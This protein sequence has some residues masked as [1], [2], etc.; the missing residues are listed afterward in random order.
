VYSEGTQGKMNKGA[1]ISNDGIV[2][3]RVSLS[4][5]TAKPRS[6]TAK[7]TTNDKAMHVT[8][9]GSIRI[10]GDTALFVVDNQH[11]ISLR[12]GHPGNT[13]VAASTI[14]N[15][16]KKGSLIYK[17]VVQKSPRPVDPTV[18]KDKAKV[19]SDNELAFQNPIRGEN[20]VGRVVFDP[21][22]KSETRYIFCINHGWLTIG[23][24]PHSTSECKAYKKAM[25]RDESFVSRNPEVCSFLETAHQENKPKEKYPGTSTKAPLRW[26]STD[27]KDE[28][29]DDTPL[30]VVDIS[31][32][33]GA[34]AKLGFGKYKNM[35]YN[36][37]LNLPGYIACLLGDL[38]KDQHSYGPYAS[39]FYRWLKYHRHIIE[40]NGVPHEDGFAKTNTKSGRGGKK[41]TSSSVEKNEDEV[42]Q[43]TARKKNGGGSATVRKSKAPTT[44]DEDV[45]T[46]AITKKSSA[47]SVRKT[48]STTLDDEEVWNTED[49]DD[50][51]DDGDQRTNSE[52]TCEA[53]ILPSEDEKRRSSRSLPK[54]SYTDINDDDIEAALVQE[55]NEATTGKHGK[56][57]KMA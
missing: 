15:K 22:T 41:S 25:I 56:K 9:T 36:S 1:C 55:Q 17:Q 12:T 27:S 57:R 30:A 48:V 39:V 5:P 21:D 45:D 23:E 53:T 35:S 34:K 20:G 16:T 49:E 54:I 42:T 7:G 28:S 43:K 38:S 24:S 8:I 3:N 31:K 18:Y 50:D 37:V 11:Q 47:K 29:P 46:S 40:T 19:W 32:V 33:N 26:K 4:P 44:K 51:D 2:S 52:S 14:T 10:S 13:I 6:A